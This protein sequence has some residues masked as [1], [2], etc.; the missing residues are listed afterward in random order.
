MQ[1]FFMQTTNTLIRA[2]VQTY[3]SLYWEYLSEGIFSH[4]VAHLQCKCIV[5][6]VS[7][8]YHDILR[9]LRMWIN[10]K[11]NKNCQIDNIASCIG[12]IKLVLTLV[13]LNKDATPISNFQPI[14][15]LQPDC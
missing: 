5:V 14:R 8:W 2:D 11:C 6:T 1:S 13:Q 15:L 4:I 12:Q 9:L 7:F 3:S 10:Y